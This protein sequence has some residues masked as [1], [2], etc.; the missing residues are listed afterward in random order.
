MSK[1]LEIPAT[2]V[3][4][5][6]SIARNTLE[7]DKQAIVFVNSKSS[8]ESQ[9]EKISVTIKLSDAKLE[10]LSEKLLLAVSSPT[11][12]CKRLA[13]CAKK[14]VAFHHA[15]LT[16]KQR[17]LIE[18]AFRDGLLRVICATPTLCLSKDSMIWHEMSE[19]KV[20]KFRNSDSLFA[21]SKNNLLSMKP[22]KIEKIK[23]SSNLIQITSVSDY[24][25]K[26]TPNHKMFIKRGDKKFLL[27]AEKLKKT[28]K[29]ATVG[30]L[31]INNIR[32]PSL[33]TFIKQNQLP[34]SNLKFNSE[35]SYFIGVM[36]GDGYSGAEYSNSEIIYKGS[37]CIV[38]IDEEIFSNA[39]KICK[40]FKISHKK[41]KNFNGTPQLIM[42]KDKWFRELMVNCGVEK[43]DK[44]YISR[45]L[46]TM[47]LENTASLLR[48]LFDTDGCVEKNSR[49][50]F[51]NIS[52]VLIKQIQKLFLRFGI[53]ST[54]KRKKSSSMKI[55][56]KEYQ[57]VPCFEILITQKQSII[58][59]YKFIGFNIKRKEKSLIDLVSKI[60]SNLNYVSCKKCNYKIYRDLFSGRTK[61]M[62]QWGK[63]KFEVINVLGMKKELGSRELKNLLGFEPK[64]KDTRLNHH[65]ELIKKRKICSISKTE[66]FWSLNEIG[67]WMYKTILSKNKE[68]IEF[69]KYKNC[70]LCQTELDWII[71]KGWRSSD[72]DG[73]IFWDCIRKIEEVDVEEEV[74]DVV[75][76][77]K[78]INNHLFLA[79]GFIV[80]NSMGLDLPAF[81]VVIRDLKRYGGPWG[82]S[83]IP[84][85]E[86]EQQA[87]R[88][89]RPGKEDYGEAICIA[90][91]NSEKE[92][93]FDK[94]VYGEPEKIFSKLAVEPVLRTH[95][96]SLIANGF[97]HDKLSMFEFFDK[98]FYAHQYADLEKLH[99]VLEKVLGLLDEWE[100]V[101]LKSGNKDFVS[102]DE[103]DN[104]FF[105]ITPIGRR[106]S[107]LYLDP[108]TANFLMTCLRRANPKLLINFSFLHML[109]STFEIRPLLRV[110][111]SEYE[112][113]Q[114]K[115]LPYSEHLLSLEPS[116]FDESYDEFLNASKTA[117]FFQDWIDE[118]SE[119]W[120]LETYNIR[121]GEV[122][123]KLELADWLL[124]STFELA[125]M[126][127]F[128]PLL[129]DISRVRVQLKYG[130][131]E[132]LL[133]LLKLRNIGRI[134][135]RKMYNN[136]LKSLTDIKNVDITT[137]SQLIGKAIAISVKKQ[138]GQEFDP[139][140]VLVKENKRKGQISLND[141]TKKRKN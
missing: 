118:K 28:D 103:F 93:I 74:F 63:N 44:K 69:F 17:E 80:H 2:Q 34:I 123:A 86:Y 85:L 84:V 60:L 10:K 39:V 68:F 112:K 53:I 130:V 1:I 94:Y 96:L 122:N 136:K 110:K 92:K 6:I 95:V 102:A 128:Q 138:L 3:D 41:N 70:P 120:L 57:T 81:R 75:L 51:S 79:N 24:K 100:F 21:L 107:E 132:E 113:V 11:R 119:E 98:T 91:T 35:L 104:G 5:V 22:Q 49:I 7:L 61:D 137:L 67:T 135:A 15:G 141:Y 46:M 116:M 48:G 76:P 97:I 36:L 38:G 19:T 127:Q 134:R 90:K 52:E 105:D 71:K 23:N 121:P 43:R 4:S 40:K 111:V 27:K 78:P 129:K 54:I 32:T 72:F 8:A 106:V 87:G 140:K 50:S 45:E 64:K 59:F 14:G 25:I 139:K 29:I 30:R 117:L 82:M 125:K 65:Y 9:A 13:L 89:G 77:E 124:Y 109:S 126:M 55:Y 16:S 18:D 73:D 133:P 99:L 37:P 62:K 83:D 115:L 56:E 108:Y 101:K 31:N 47:S 66:W 42:G 26:V 88:A 131:K 58:D 33:K 12:Q 114:E 20:S